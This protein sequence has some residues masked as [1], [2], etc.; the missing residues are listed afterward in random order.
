MNKV[1]LCG[2]LTRD[3][4][5][6]HYQNATVAR[7]AIAVDRRFSK[8]K[9]VDFI[10]LTAFGKT[11]EFMQKYMSFKGLRILVEGRLQVSQYEKNGEKRYSTEVVVESVEFADGKKDSGNA[12]GNVDEL[13]GEPIDDS[14]TPF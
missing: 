14:D 13:G 10:N 8:E 6:K 1:I 12:A 4:E 5:V 11:A 7:T 9:A 3:V 2:R